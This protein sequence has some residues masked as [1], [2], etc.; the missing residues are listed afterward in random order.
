MKRF[1]RYIAYREL[2]RWLRNVG[3]DTDSSP[4]SSDPSA[5][6]DEQSSQRRVDE[7]PIEEGPID[8]VDEL[9][10]LLQ[11]MDPYKFEQFV[12]DLWTR[13][14]WQTDV[15]TASMDEGVDVIARKQTPYE[16]TTL[17]QARRYGPNTTVGSP[18]IQQYASLDQQYAGVDDVVI[19]TITDF[20]GRARDL[21]ERLNVKLSNGDTL[22]ELVVDHDAL[23][24]V[25]EYLESVATV[26]REDCN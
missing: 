14:G 11:Q 3:N 6:A 20:T 8:S 21:A 24:L 16:Q 2:Y 7:L 4:Q 10:L 12:A 25:D 26:E 19:V 23:A 17:I 1:L 9:T 5:S 18:D 22:A 15:S 13:M